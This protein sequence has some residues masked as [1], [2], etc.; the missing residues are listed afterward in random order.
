[1]THLKTLYSV[2]AVLLLC[3][4]MTTGSVW[5]QAPA[6]KGGD[7][8]TTSKMQR[9]QGRTQMTTEQ[10]QKMMVKRYQTLLGM[11]DEELAVIGPYVLKVTT[12]SSSTQTRGTGRTMIMGGRG[13]TTQGTD[14]QTQTRGN[15]GAEQQDENLTAL[16]TLL[17]DENASSDEIKSKLSAFRKAQASAKQ[18]L[19]VAQK[20]LRELLTLRQE[21]LL[22]TMGLLE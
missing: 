18:E 5:A 10:M 2:I 11:S 15:R 13:N 4:F 20:E 17:E 19:A 22:V 16:S 1:M 7:S 14:A 21:A 6:E 8:E 3:L 12:L 9:G